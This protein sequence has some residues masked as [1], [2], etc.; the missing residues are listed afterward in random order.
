MPLRDPSC[1]CSCYAALVMMTGQVRLHKE[2]AT[3]ADLELSRSGDLPARQ[4][5]K[6]VEKLL[7]G[8]VRSASG[9]C[10]LAP[11][12]VINASGCMKRRCTRC[13]S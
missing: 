5:G 10:A 2:E 13:H 7:I 3:L 12:T 1:P 8:G 11:L 6:T 4:E 9:H